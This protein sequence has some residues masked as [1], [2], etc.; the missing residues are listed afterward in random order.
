ME[1]ILTQLAGNGIIGIIL[2]WF[3]L[4]NTKLT[5]ELFNVI[6]NN[7]EAMAELKSSMNELT[8]AQR[9]RRKEFQ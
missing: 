5:D 3:M 4:R 9:Q 2:A 8:Q 6:K 7:T 1:Q